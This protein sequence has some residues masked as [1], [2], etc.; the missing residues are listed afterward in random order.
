MHVHV[1]TLPDELGE[2]LGGGVGQLHFGTKEILSSLLCIIETLTLLQYWM[3]QSEKQVYNKYRILSFFCQTVVNTFRNSEGPGGV[4]FAR[5]WLVFFGKIRVFE[6]LV[7]SKCLVQFVRQSASPLFL[8]YL[9]H[10][11]N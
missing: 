9:I 8:K 11:L 3:M 7:K 2:K 4:V 10:Q 1:H 6:R 5:E